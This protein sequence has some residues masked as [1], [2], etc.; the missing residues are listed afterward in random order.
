MCDD[1]NVCTDD[2]CD[3][4]SGCTHIANNAPCDDGDACTTGDACAA[5]ACVGG[6]P[7]NCNDQNVCTDDDCDPQ[8]GCT[9]VANMAPCNDGDACTT[10]D[11]C[12]A[13]SCVSG[14]PTDCDDQNDCT[15]DSCDA[16]TGCAHEPVDD[17]C[18]LDSECADS[19]AC[20]TNERCESHK[21]VSDP[22]DCADTNDCTDDGCDPQTGCTHLANAA[23]CDDG[24]KCTSGDTCAATVCAGVPIDCNDSDVCTDDSCNPMTGCVNT[25]NTAPCSDGNGCTVGDACAGGSCVPGAMA[26]C[27]DM[28]GCTDDSCNP[29]T[30]QC[31]HTPNTAP[32]DD[33]NACTSG[34]VCG[35]GSC[36]GAPVD[37][38]D[39]NVCTDDSCDPA[40]GCHHEAN[41]APCSDGDPCTTGDTCAAKACGAGDPV[42]CNDGNVCTDDSCDPATGMCI[43]APN[44]AACSDDDACTT[45]DVCSGG[46]CV[47]GPAPDCVDTNPCT[48]D[49]CDAVKGCVHTDN[50]APCD[51]QNPCTENDACASGACAPGP[52]KS[53]DDNQ[54]CTDDSCNPATGLCENVNNSAPCDDGNVCTAG[55]ICFQGACQPGGPK[56]CGDGNVCT[57]DV[58][59]PT[60]DCQHTA[61]PDCCNTDAE[62]ADTDECTTN[63]RCVNHAC[64][65]DP[66]DCADDDICT[67]DTCNNA[68]GGFLCVHTACYLVQGQPCEDETCIPPPGCG[69]SVVDPQ[70]GETCD[71]PGST[72]VPGF[73]CRIDCTYCGD[74][75]LQ[76]QDGE[77]C[78]DGNKVQGCIKNDSF[79]V[80]ACQNNCTPHIC[81]DPTKAMLAEF[82]DGFTFHGRL[83]AT[84]DIDFAN[85][86]FAIE[87]TEASGHVIYRTSVPSGAMEAYGAIPG[88]RYRYTSRSAKRA[89]GIAKIKV[90]R[91]R[92]SY[93]TTV[94]AFGNLLGVKKDMVT[95]VHAGKTQWSLNGTWTQRGPRLWRFV[96]PKH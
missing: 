33:G 19:D 18:N 46:K 23:P 54:P 52:T 9:H 64:V 77:T 27:G 5:K 45:G 87:L 3:P 29:M 51:D 73:T 42:L 22:V 59:G 1:G 11:A 67:V 62:C 76:A 40:T 47:G 2:G 90:R 93:R 68:G 48:D 43:H 37:C 34:D 63:E 15:T 94:Q 72:P 88:A 50:S 31:V 44:G 92:E 95:R 16:V 32:C 8:T 24:S 66:R 61:K 38:D 79:P 12:A 13:K 26:D 4:A 35:G 85:T 55:D 6:P 49:S 82:I 71:P 69:D 56:D 21:C 75:A 81:R 36:G 96:E 58:C 89:G 20:T 17:C 84:T 28:N 7:P 14:P 91:N 70:L 65:S 83:T 57:L 30:G 78:D 25:P 60:T 53:C 10:G 41:T 74:G 80:D 39:T 86:N